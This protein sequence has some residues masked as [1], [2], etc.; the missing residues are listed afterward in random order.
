MKNFFSLLCIFTS[1]CCSLCGSSIKKTYSSQE[2]LS[3]LV[4]TQSDVSDVAKSPTSVTATSMTGDFFSLYIECKGRC[5]TPPVS[6]NV[7]PDSP[8]D[9]CPISPISPLKSALTEKLNGTK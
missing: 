5:H 1:I 3:R 8:E 6:P 7:V 4:G 9:R 2:E